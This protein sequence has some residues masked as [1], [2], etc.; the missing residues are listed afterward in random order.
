M[1]DSYDQ[2]S[3]SYGL[4]DDSN[5]IA[6]IRVIE[7]EDGSGLGDA[8]LFRDEV[9]SSGE[10]IRLFEAVFTEQF[11]AESSHDHVVDLL[12]SSASRISRDSEYNSKD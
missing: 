11:D 5:L 2:R 3:V 8:F 12:R 1:I 6:A 7:S 9:V 4:F 10:P